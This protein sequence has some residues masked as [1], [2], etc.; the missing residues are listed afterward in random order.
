MKDTLTVIHNRRSIRAYADRPISEDDVAALKEATLRAPSAGN[1]LYY[2]VIEAKDQQVKDKLA[3]YC[4]NQPMIAKAP[5]VW[6]FLADTQK[7]VNYFKEGGSVAR[8]ERENT[9]TWRKP[10]LGDMHLCMQDAI[11]AAQTAVLA[12]ETMG[13]GSCYIGDIIEHYEEVR[14]LLDLKQYTIPACMVIFGYPKN[15]DNK[16]ALKKRCPASSVFMTDRYTEPH[17]PELRQAYGELENDLRLHNRLPFDNAG[18]IADFYYFRKYASDFMEEMNRS[19]KV[20]ME[21]WDG[22]EEA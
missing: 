15:P 16:I 5:L 1:M 13:I 2:S 6:V 20:F 4:D 12:A 22:P 11:I 21:R 19:T 18:S 14:D 17:L 3:V 7:W 9:A 8:G 10:G